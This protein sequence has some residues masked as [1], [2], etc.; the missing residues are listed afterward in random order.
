MKDW[1]TNIILLF[2][3]LIPTAVI[4]SRLVFLQVVKHDF[5]NALAQGQQNIYSETKG[6]R[7]EIY[8]SDKNND[9]Y[10]V[11]MDKTAKLCFAVLNEIENKEEVS[12][13]LSMILDLK[14]EGLLSNFSKTEINFLVIKRGL[15][16]EEVEKIE[17]LNFPGI[18]LRDQ[19]VREYP[20]GDFASHIIGFVNNDGL[21]QY[22]VEQFYN[23]TL[24][25]KES[26][27]E[28]KKGPAGY[29]SLS[30][31]N[32]L[33]GSNLILTVDYNIQ[34]KAEELLKK[35]YE[36]LD[37]EGGQIIVMDPLSG[38]ILSMAQYPRYDLNSYSDYDYEIFK[39]GSV[40]KLF[41]PG[42]VFKPITM[43]GALNE[44]KITPQT[45][46]EDPGMIRVSGHPIYNYD[47]RIY[48]GEITMTEVL[49]KS[50]NTGAVFA[51]SQLGNEKFLEYI[52]KFS[53]FKP[54]NIDLPAEAFSQNK[55]FKK[56]YDINFA[57]ASFGQGLEITP[58]QLV[59]AF[60]AISNGGKMVKPYLIKGIQENGNIIETQ[61]EISKT[62][63][64]SNETS[65]K[66]TAM[67]VS[68]IK[69][70]FAKKAQIP[71]YYIAG[72][73][74]TAQVSFSSLGEDGVGYSDKTWQSFIGWFP[75][76]EPKF[77]IFV[78]LDNPK[79]KTAEY[80]ALPIFKD[81]VKYII[82][83]WQVLP[84]Y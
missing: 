45:T 60:S 78:K 2:F 36:D 65:S 16:K 9:L 71:G 3:I 35:T 32:A 1:R 63:V 56:G 10:L 44:G 82:D 21:G 58:I 14:E 4:I 53:F 51:Q 38:K 73:T 42:S 8:F 43:A 69:N 72:K 55:E 64:I 15:E 7:G 54:T 12:Q 24:T 68:V 28:T 83:Y 48:S 34:F 31:R 17:N 27:I 33:E 79:T 47:Q 52:E 76:F 6:K 77:L 74:G 39:N 80:S 22:G 13:E 81:L 59:K 40:Q 57:N 61:P 66:L 18:F 26:F 20:Y 29:L 75:A 49:E 84:N 5:Y 11:A 46:Y 19:I 23:D 25:G 41:E 50:I 67:M 70:G 37:I 62:N 30:D